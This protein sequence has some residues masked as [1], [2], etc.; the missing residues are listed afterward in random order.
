M[1]QGAAGIGAPGGLAGGVREGLRGELTRAGVA[2]GAPAG[3]GEHGRAVPGAEFLKRR[4][5]GRGVGAQRLGQPDVGRARV[6]TRVSV[7]GSVAV[8]GSVPRSMSCLLKACPA[9]PSS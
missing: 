5:R 8:D 2:R 6:R 9:D 3:V 1:A 4:V 7:T